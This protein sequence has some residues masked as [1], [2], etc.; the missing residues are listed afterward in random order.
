MKWLPI[1]FGV[2]LL[3]FAG[4]GLF[5]DDEPDDLADRFFPLKVGQEWT[6][7]VTESSVDTSDFGDIFPTRFTVAVV[8]KRSVDGKIYFLL[9]NYFV[10]G[11]FLPDTVLVRND[12]SRVLIR[13]HP[14][15]DEIVFYSFAPP[16]TAW[17]VPMYA[18]PDWLLPS[19]AL[20]EEW[21]DQ[22]A[23]V[24]WRPGIESYWRE[25]FE[26]GV[27]RLEI[28]LSTADF[29]PVVWTLDRSG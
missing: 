10:P 11:P 5:S 18:N 25:T 14:E 27:G 9:H 26:T 4:C 21:S 3:P 22:S 29:H 28:R 15:D 19:W 23:T 2:A 17:S 6:Y 13:L 8:D 24:L 20:L 1:L 16:D 7:E 12:D